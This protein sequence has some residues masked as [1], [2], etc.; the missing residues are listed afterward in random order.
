[1]SVSSSFFFFRIVAL[2]T[3]LLECTAEAFSIKIRKSAEAKSNCSSQGAAENIIE[4][5][6]L[7]NFGRKLQN[8][9]ENSKSGAH[10]FGMEG[11]YTSDET[12]P[13]LNMQCSG[14]GRT[15]YGKDRNSIFSSRREIR[16]AFSESSGANNNNFIAGKNSNRPLHGKSSGSGCSIIRLSGDDAK[17]VRDLVDY[18][19]EF[20][21]RVDSDKESRN[22]SVKKVGVFKIDQ[23]V[24]AGFDENV[25]DEGRMQ[26]LDTRI[27]S[28]SGTC[29]DD[30]EDI[31]IPMEVGELVGADSLIHAHKGISTLIDIGC[32]ITSAVLEMHSDSA[33]KLID[34]GTMR[35]EGEGKSTMIGKDAVSNSYH[36]L[37]RYIN[38]QPS[39]DEDTASFRSHVDSSFLT[40]IP[41][42]KLPG[43]E[44]WSPCLKN[45]QERGGEWVRPTRPDISDDEE[46]FAYV[47][48][49]AGEFLQ[50][51]SNGKV[52]TCIHRVLPPVPGRISAPLFLRPRRG[53][54]AVLNVALDLGQ[55]YNDDG[56]YFEPG[57]LDECDSMHLW[58][59]HGILAKNS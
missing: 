44:I 20:F 1:M 36:R 47:I 59:V 10:R 55:T 53:D 42:P 46:D 52:P 32:Q 25:N 7:H 21:E 33:G 16:E 15:V 6:L 38:S 34:D 50:L 5:P 57:L 22:A 35:L 8:R 14:G 23:F 39:T 13:C 9:I 31:L 26:M 29:N 11:A 56:L 3:V 54:D 49:M 4:R 18:A 58:S 17:C 12:F 40:L 41:M 48:A 43:L 19:N 30:R 37:I 24:Y 51:T 45:D 28:N 2:T 27:L